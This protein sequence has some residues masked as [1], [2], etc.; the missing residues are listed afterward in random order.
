MFG[1]SVVG[2]LTCSLLLSGGVVLADGQPSSDTMK[3]HESSKTIKGTVLRIEG[4]NYF[5]KTAED[6]KQIRLHIDKTTK[7][8]LVATGDKVMAK[9]GDQDHVE[10]IVTEQ[11]ASTLH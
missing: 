2:A 1:R 10:S 7:M 9:I 5:V 6:G 11:S 8:N 3:Q 4:P